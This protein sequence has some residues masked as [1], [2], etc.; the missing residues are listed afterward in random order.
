VLAALVKN[1]RTLPGDLKA[2][3]IGFADTW[4]YLSTE[5]GAKRLTSAKLLARFDLTYEQ[6][7]RW[8]DPAA[9]NTAKLRLANEEVSDAD[10]LKNPY[11]L[12]ECDRLQPEPIAFRT[13][14]QGAFPEKPVANAHPVPA[15]SAMT[16]PVDGRRLRGATA[17]VLEGAASEG[18]CRRQHRRF[19]PPS[20]RRTAASSFAAPG[21]SHRGREAS[22]NSTPASPRLGRSLTIGRSMIFAAALQLAWPNSASRRI[23]SKPC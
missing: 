5:R 3:I 6:A 13:I 9:R 12:Y 16:G 2:Q 7:A 1:P 15:P 22:G 19:L 17:A 23:S 4:K 10:I 20:N 21:P 14:D 18:D 8:W 11:I